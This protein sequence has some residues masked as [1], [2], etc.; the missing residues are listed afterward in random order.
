MQIRKPGREERR[1]R[2][3]WRASAANLRRAA[4]VGFLASL[5]DSR[6]IEAL[7]GPI[8]ENLR[9]QRPDASHDE[10]EP[11]VLA[12]VSEVL[13][14]LRRG[15]EFATA[16]GQLFSALDLDG[17]VREIA[18]GRDDVSVTELHAEI[19]RRERTRIERFAGPEAADA[20]VRQVGPSLALKLHNFA[21]GDQGVL[22][23]AAAI[24]HDAL[25]GDGEARLAAM[26]PV[27]IAEANGAAARGM[28]REITE[29]LRDNNFV[30]ADLKAFYI[31]PAPEGYP[32]GWHADAVLGRLMPPIPE[33]IGT[34]VAE[35]CAT[36]TGAEEAGRAL[37]VSL[38][39]VAHALGDPTHPFA[40]RPTRRI[41]ELEAFLDMPERMV[42]D[43]PWIDG[44]FDLGRVHLP[45]RGILRS[46]RFLAALEECARQNRGV[47][48]GIDEGGYGTLTAFIGH[49]RTD[50]GW[51]AEL[52]EA[53]RRRLAFE[54]AGASEGRAA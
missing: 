49:C 38:V 45:S 29:A 16:D 8:R 36:M 43:F 50:P 12:G 25:D 1:A 34:A 44:T 19:M 3:A 33:A 24:D 21:L 27:A 15:G 31:Y 10:L 37:L 18:P 30:L 13:G 26:L 6:L 22:P 20:M 52:Q 40:A 14:A 11:E 32:S 47:P 17:I 4:R 23:V 35:P 51:F 5:G 53:A 42:I 41:R 39:S 48:G 54:A 46:E 7:A 9:R 28:G 2:R